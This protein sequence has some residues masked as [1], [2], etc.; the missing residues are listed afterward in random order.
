MLRDGMH[1]TAVH[2]GVAPYHPNSLDGGCPFQAGADVGGFVEVPQPVPAAERVRALSA[3]FDDHTSQPRMFWLSLSDVE[4]QHLVDGFTFE[5]G[6]CYETPI[7]ERM[8]RV[9]AD[10]DTELCARVAEGLGLSAPESTG[11]LPDVRPSPALSQ[12]GRSWPVAGRVV[13]IVIDGNSDPGAVAAVR[14]ATHAAGMTPLIIAPRGSVLPGAGGAELTVQRTYQTARS[15]EFDAVLVAGTLSS[16]PDP[17]IQLLLAEAYRHCKALGGWDGAGS[18]FQAAGCPE[19]GDGML[20]V[21]SA[22]DVLAGVTDLLAHHRV[23]SRATAAD[24][25]N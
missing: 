20:F 14:D 2:S 21:G 8:L 6:K 22:T 9:L 4:R 11:A 24:A 19:D 10:V 5:L 3:S 18:V 17:R 16:P 23:W 13:G 25:G 1:Q 12:L 15:V 7:R